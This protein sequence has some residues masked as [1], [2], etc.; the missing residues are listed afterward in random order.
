MLYFSP[1]VGLA[2]W[3]EM[4]KLHRLTEEQRALTSDGRDLRVT[5]VGGYSDETNWVYRDVAGF[6]PIDIA[7]IDAVFRKHI[8]P[9]NRAY[10]EVFSFFGCYSVGV[11]TWEIKLHSQTVEG[12]I[13]K[14]EH[15]FDRYPH[16]S[17]TYRV[18]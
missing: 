6:S 2:E 17:W 9:N 14:I 8:S 12:L 15:Y 5:Q 18:A 1:D 13:E 11:H 7:V 3:R 16:H 4:S 10:W